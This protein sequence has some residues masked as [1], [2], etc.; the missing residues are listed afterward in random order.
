MMLVGLA[1]TTALFATRGGVDDA[2]ATHPLNEAESPPGDRADA[3]QASTSRKSVATTAA[4]APEPGTVPIRT[5]EPSGAEQATV[6]TNA[7]SPTA[8]QPPVASS[9]EQPPVGTSSAGAPVSE[10]G[11]PAGVQGP[12]PAAPSPSPSPSASAGPGSV[13]S[14]APSSTAAPVP[15]PVP[16]PITR[17]P[18]PTSTPIP[19]PVPITVP[20]PDPGQPAPNPA[21]SATAAEPE[22]SEQA[23]ADYPTA[24]DGHLAVPDPRP[25]PT[26]TLPVTEP[27]EIPE[28]T[29][30]DHGADN[31]QDGG[32]D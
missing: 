17:L 11:S 4:R 18:A 12:E 8:V 9:P 20:T 31:D 22:P 30:H 13:V 29:T 25:E 7:G 24:E 6:A 14:A 2:S 10:S 21:P 26:S 27:A 16:D 28:P 23:G 19:S 3:P 15:Q 32:D 5:V 1:A